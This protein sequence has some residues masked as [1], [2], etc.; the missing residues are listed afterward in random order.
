MNQSSTTYTKC[1][2]LVPS[3]SNLLLVPVLLPP[4]I[5]LPPPLTLTPLKRVSSPIL[6]PLAN[7]PAL[8][9]VPDI[10]SDLIRDRYPSI[11]PAGTASPSPIRRHTRDSN[12]IQSHLSPTITTIYR[13]PP[14]PPPQH[15]PFSQ[16]QSP[17][18]PMSATEEETTQPLS[19][20]PPRFKKRV[21]KSEED[22][23]PVGPSGSMRKR[24]NEN[25]DDGDGGTGT[26]K[27]TRRSIR[28]LLRESRGGGVVAVPV[29]DVIPSRRESKKPT[30]TPPEPEAEASTSTIYYTQRSFTN[31]TEPIEISQDL[32]LFYRR[33]PASSYFKNQDGES[34]FTKPHPGGTYNAPKGPFDLYT[35]RFVKGKGR[36]KM[37]LCPICV[38]PVE[39][40]GEGKNVWLA[41]KFSA[42]KCICTV[43][44]DTGISAASSLPFSPPLAFRV[45]RRPRVQK[46]EKTTIKEGK[47][48][49]CQKWIPV[50]GVKDMEVKVKEIFWWKHAATCHRSQASRTDSPAEARDDL[51]EKDEVFTRL[52]EFEVEMEAEVD[53]DGVVS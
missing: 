41:M 25:V 33:F 10:F 20:L 15:T 40:G 17:L 14:R 44:L 38:E 18:T 35:P 49:Q 43:E 4:S 51:F 31:Q 39:R 8:T 13:T 23:G 42:Y 32:H 16:P 24:K 7:G 19:T 11:S 5:F 3:T 50:E 29:T 28:Q 21:I 2:V 48:H 52:K 30:P 9:P 1:F 37:G 36:D 47:C 12:R 26:G 27:R 46:S 34:L 6:S 45:S 22:A 53:S